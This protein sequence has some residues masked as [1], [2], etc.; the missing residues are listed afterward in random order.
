ML[1]QISTPPRFSELT[2]EDRAYLRSR[3]K[4]F[5][6]QRDASERQLIASYARR[7]REIMIANSGIPSAFVSA[8]ITLCDP[9]IRSYVEAA[10]NGSNA[11]LVI[12]GVAG[13]GKTYAA[14]A[15]LMQLVAK[16]SIRYVTLPGFVRAVNSTYSKKG[17]TAQDVFAEYAG[18]AYL[19]LDDIGKEVPRE[20][21]LTSLW[22]LIDQRY[23]NGKPT[24]YTSQYSGRELYKRLS[25][26]GDDKT[27]QAIISRMA[28]NMVV[29]F[30]NKDRRGRINMKIDLDGA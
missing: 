24:I 11:G 29:V 2:E 30:E 7:A 17:V 23:A 13:S 28:Q 4:E 6:A 27:A 16:K 3:R 8:D 9:R 15:I 26:N 18:A 19:L 25:I 14:C 12:R 22:E 1:K 10:Q 5:E 20:T 21:N